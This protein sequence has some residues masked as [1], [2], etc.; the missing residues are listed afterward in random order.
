MLQLHVFDDDFD[1][2]SRDGFDLMTT[3]VQCQKR[4]FSPIFREFAILFSDNEVLHKNI[5]GDES[6]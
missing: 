3:H 6:L 2:L 1:Q 5:N 4:Q